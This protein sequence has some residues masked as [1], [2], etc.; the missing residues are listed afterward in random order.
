MAELEQGALFAGYRIGQVLG[1]G[2]MGIVYEATEIALDRRVA[3]KLIAAD[4]ARDEAFREQFERESRVAAKVDDPHVIPIYTVGREG[5]ALFIAMRLVPGRD[6]G[7][8][9]AGRRLEPA[10][11]ARLISQVADGLDAIHEAGLIHRD[12][13]PSNILLAGGDGDEHAYVADFG[14]AKQAATSSGLTR[15]GRVVGTIDY[16]SPEQI[17]QRQVDARADVYSLGCVLYKSLTGRV[18]FERDSDA[19]KLW[20]HVHEEPRPP[21]ALGGVPGDF[22]QVIERALAKRPEDRYPSAGD[23]GRAAVAAAAGREVTASE[24]WVATGVA[25]GEAPRLMLENQEGS[26]GDLAR[27]YAHDELTPRLGARGPGSRRRGFRVPRAVVFALIGAAVGFGVF[28][29]ERPG[30][31]GPSPQLKRLIGR[32][33]EICT[34]SR[35]RFNEAASRRVET[36]EQAARQVE[37]QHAVSVSALRQLRR[38]N[39]PPEVAGEWSRYLHLREVQISRLE[40]ARKAALGGN[41]LAYQRAQRKLAEGRRIRFEAARRV[42]LRQCS[43]GA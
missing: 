10:E 26:T 28:L 30:D 35:V 33:D 23:L 29:I 34:E 7:E 8:K 12:V 25:A 13:K 27:R 1:R 5:E 24:R 20:A 38:L 36:F 6:L 22:D 40:Q 43:R 41:N 17:E 14:L 19:A 37:H 4:A 32:A 3:L 31:S 21:S 2:G 15:R 42:G 11:A 39:A 18:P 9:L 16:V